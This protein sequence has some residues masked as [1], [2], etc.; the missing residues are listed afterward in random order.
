M[1]NVRRTVGYAVLKTSPLLRKKQDINTH[2]RVS[3]STNIQLALQEKKPKNDKMIFRYQ[4]MITKQFDFN[5]KRLT[6]EHPVTATAATPNPCH[7]SP[8]H[9]PQVVAPSL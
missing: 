8:G 2:N 4:K 1:K 6:T 3:T 9:W 7:C 5:P